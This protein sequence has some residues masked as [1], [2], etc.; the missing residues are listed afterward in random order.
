MNRLSYQGKI[1]TSYEYSKENDFESDIRK[2]RIKV[3]TFDITL[4]EFKQWE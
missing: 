4:K 2:S 1:F 3:S